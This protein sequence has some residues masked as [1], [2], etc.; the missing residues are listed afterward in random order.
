M[1]NEIIIPLKIN[2]KLFAKY[3]LR[4]FNINVLNFVFKK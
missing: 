3:F 2:K 1:F 4:V